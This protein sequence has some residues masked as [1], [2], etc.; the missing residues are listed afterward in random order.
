MRSALQ[1][2]ASRLNGAKSQGPKTAAGKRRSSK[3]ATKHN[4]YS[5][6]LIAKGETRRKFDQFFA[7]CID[8]YQPTSETQ[9]QLVA[10]I[11][12]AKWRS[13]RVLKSARK[14]DNAALDSEHNRQARSL[15]FA[16]DCFLQERTQQNLAASPCP[17][18]KSGENPPGGIAS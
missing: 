1:I 16:I 5:K 7:H 14:Q 13:R 12:E 15:L 18:S 17:T 10:A 8:D 9:L 11:A 3:N 6:S 2:Q 4:A